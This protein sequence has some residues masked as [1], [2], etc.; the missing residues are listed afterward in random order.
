MKRLVYL[1]VLI[2]IFSCR[3]QEIEEEPKLEEVVIV[4]PESRL[5]ICNEG[6]FGWGNATISVYNIDKGTLSDSV[7]QK[8]N[9]FALGDVCQ[10]ATIYNDKIYVVVNNSA[11]I[12]VLN[13]VSY[14]VEAS[15]SG[16]NS[17]RY[18]LPI[19]SKKAYVSDL[20]A[21]EIAVINLENNSVSSKIACKGWT[22]E[23]ALINDKAYITNIES[24]YLYVIN[25]A[26]DAK[27]D[28]IDVGFGV[29][30]IQV[31]GQNRV[32]CLRGG[33]NPALLSLSS[34][35][36]VKDFPLASGSTPSKLRFSSTNNKLY[37]IDTG[38][39]EFDIGTETFKNDFV[40]NNDNVFYGL[41]INPKNGDV[42]VSDA[43][44]F[45]QNSTV[46]VYDKLGSFK[47]TFNSGVNT[48]YFVF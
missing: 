7:F 18:F 47:T 48:G 25:T 23:V 26:D 44:D 17:P 15:I 21:D 14:K 41:G 42:Y 46:H 40:E 1:L 29:S 36:S 3:K 19:D 45:T 5:I 8:A 4:E 11:K 9:D 22:E 30:S 10:S 28:S 20:Y 37:F 38:V 31:D 6:N 43:K 16:F 32:W 27:E 24:Q 35:N 2:S 34:D 13:N 33:D 12:E 39:A